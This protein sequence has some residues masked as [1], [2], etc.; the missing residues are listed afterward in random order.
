MKLINNYATKIA[1]LSFMFVSLIAASSANT[2]ATVREGN[3][4]AKKAAAKPT[5]KA[6][7]AVHTKTAKELRTAKRNEVTLE[8]A[9]ATALKK[10]PGT[11][12]SEEL[13][14]EKGMR[15]YSFDIQNKKGKTIEL[16]V[17]QK[18]GKIVRRATE[19]AA[20]ERKERQK[21]KN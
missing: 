14:T 13:E 2:F 11:I 19:S 12:K 3:K 10:V 4:T 9:R 20:A 21:E 1:F 5:T 17:S 8:Q 7:T 18:T 15:V 16:W 6:T